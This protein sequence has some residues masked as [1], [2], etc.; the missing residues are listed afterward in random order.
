MKFRGSGTVALRVICVAAWLALVASMVIPKGELAFEMGRMGV[1]VGPTCSIVLA[2]RRLTL[3]VTQVFEVG[4]R[5][6]REE[7]ASERPRLRV[8][9]SD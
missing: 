2:L 8:V 5:V 1:A 7:S 3:P 4:R 9:E 6:G